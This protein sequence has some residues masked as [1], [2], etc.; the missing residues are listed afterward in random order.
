LGSSKYI[1]TLV[2]F[3]GILSLVPSQ[4]PGW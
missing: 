2:P 1:D 4:N 3:S